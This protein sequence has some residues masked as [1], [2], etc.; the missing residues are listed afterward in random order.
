MLFPKAGLLS[1]EVSDAPLFGNQALPAGNV[2]EYRVGANS[3]SLFHIRTA[4]AL[5]AAI[6]LSNYKATLTGVKVE[7]GFG[8]FSGLDGQTPVFVFAKDKYLL[9]VRGLPAKQA[10][11]VARQFAALVR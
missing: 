8:G 9:G 7:A 10:D 11:G 1:S 3:Y 2:A 4:S 6:L 5:D